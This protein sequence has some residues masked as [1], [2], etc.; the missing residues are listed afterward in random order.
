MSKAQRSPSEAH[1]EALAK[2]LKIKARPSAHVLEKYVGAG[3]STYRFLNLSTP[4]LRE[5]ADSDFDFASGDNA[6]NTWAGWNAIWHESDIYDL[7]IVAT[8]WAA[9][10]SIEDLWKHRKILLSWSRKA[11]NWALADSMCSIYARLFEAHPKEM[12]K[13]LEAW[14]RSKNPWERRMSNVSLFYYSRSRETLPTYKFAEK[15]ILRQLEDRHYYVQKGVGWAL[16][17]CWNVYPQKTFA[18]LKKIA[19]Q[20]PSAAWTAATEKLS[21]GEKKQL[22]ALRAKAKSPRK[23]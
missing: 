8:I 2:I 15:L 7:L 12:S 13:I 5:F 3:V 10:Q 4:Q 20:I 1:Q 21:P 11:D 23:R 9:D 19:P 16:R 17:E 18:L 22:A 14:S 6:A